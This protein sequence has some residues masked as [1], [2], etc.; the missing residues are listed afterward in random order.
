MRRRKTAREYEEI[1][2]KGNYLPGI[3]GS[4]NRGTGTGQSDADPHVGR[5][6]IFR[7]WQP[8]T[9]IIPM[10]RM[11]TAHDILLCIQTGKKLS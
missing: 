3:A 1:F 10:Q 7:W 8:M 4:W 11:R 6:W 2:G 5:D 9:Y